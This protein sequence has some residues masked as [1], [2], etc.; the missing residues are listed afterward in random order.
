MLK[1]IVKRLLIFIPTLFAISLLTFIISISA[2]G[3]PV[4]ARLHRHLE[5]Q[6]G[7]FD[8]KQQ[9]YEKL[10][11]LLGLDRPVFYA[12]VTTATQPDTRYRL[13]IRAQRPCWG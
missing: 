1:Y 5:D 13:P 8:S 2:P 11:A 10:R 4:D 6:L 9:E 3:D 7:Q 12:T